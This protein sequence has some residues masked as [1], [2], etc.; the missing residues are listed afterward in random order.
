[1]SGMIAGQI[2]IAAT[3][4]SVTSSVATLAASFMPAHTGDVTSPAGSTVNTLATVNANVGAFQGLTVNAKGLVTAA[5]NQNYVTGGPYL[6]LAGGTLTGTLAV[7]GNANPAL[8]VVAS[9]TVLYAPDGTAGSRAILIQ[10]AAAGAV[11][12]HRNTGHYFQDAPGSNTFG[13]FTASGLNVTGPVASTSMLQASGT[14][15]RSGTAGPSQVNN[16]N[17]Q[18][19]GTAAHLWVD[20]FDSGAIT[21]TCDYR[22]KE[23]IVALASTWDKVKAL[24]PVSCTRLIPP[25]VGALSRMNCRRRCLRARRLAT[26]TRL[27]WC[28]HLT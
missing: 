10:S 23:N 12:F 18:W 2:P 4:T 7:N 16:Y 9:A 24:R 8:A 20:T 27:T 21:V 19:T 26:R 17:I 22:I 28:N 11:T 6:P 15:S 14:Q 1:M 13:A 5:A 25:S 3:A